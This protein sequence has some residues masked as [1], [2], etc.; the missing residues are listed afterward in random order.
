MGFLKKL[1][2]KSDDKKAK[3]FDPEEVIDKPFK[4]GRADK[5]LDPT[6]PIPV[7]KDPT[8]KDK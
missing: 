2:K 1:F 7:P 3:K 6:N 8:I 4:P 5:P